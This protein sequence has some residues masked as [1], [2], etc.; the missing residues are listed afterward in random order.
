MLQVVSTSTRQWVSLFCP[1]RFK[2]VSSRTSLRKKSTWSN[3]IYQCLSI[4][5]TQLA[6]SLMI[7]LISKDE[8]FKFYSYFIDEILEFQFANIFRIKI[9]PFSLFFF[10][11]IILFLRFV[12]KTNNYL[13]KLFKTSIYV[14]FW[15][16]II[17]SSVSWAYWTSCC[18]TCSQLAKA[19]RPTTFA[20]FVSSTWCTR[21]TR[22]WTNNRWNLLHSSFDATSLLSSLWVRMATWRLLGPRI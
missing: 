1:I 21:H 17:I 12:F 22:K 16:W 20:S 5:S 3:S 9:T 2:T 11:L 18:P 14:Y 7:H 13:I 10:V 4:R 6:V 8:S 15:R 19:P